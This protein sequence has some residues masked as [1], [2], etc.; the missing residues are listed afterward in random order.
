MTRQNGLDLV[1]PGVADR[2]RTNISTC[3][4][5]P[6]RQLIPNKLSPMPLCGTRMPYG[7]SLPQDLIDCVD[8]YI[9]A[10]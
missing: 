9:D 10:L 6:L 5:L 2:I 8:R 3:R 1:S 7:G 4:G